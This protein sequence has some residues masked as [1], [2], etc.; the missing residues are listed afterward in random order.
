MATEV[1]AQAT[2][3]PF[4]QNGIG[5]IIPAGSIANF[6]MG[7]VGISNG[8]IRYVNVSNP[9]LLTY[10]SV[11]TFSAGIV[12]GNVKLSNGSAVERFGSANL[13]QINMSF[14]VIAGKWTSALVLRPYSY[15]HYKYSNTVQVNGTT[16]DDIQKVEG[17]GGF[18]QLMW[19]NGVKITKGLSLGGHASYIFGSI[20]KEY[21]NQL[22]DTVVVTAY[23]PTRT[24]SDAVADFIYGLGASYSYN[25]R[26]KVKL[27]F[28]LTY[29]FQSNVKTKKFDS[30]ERQ[31]SAGTSSSVFIL[32]DDAKGMTKLPSSLGLGI[33]V[34]NSLKWSAGVDIKMQDWSQFRNFEGSNEGLDKAFSVALGGEITPDAG[35]INNFLKR[36][37]YRLGLSYEDTPYSENGNS[38]QDFGINFGFSLPVTT[39]S[40]LDMGFKYG[41]RGNV[42]KVGLKEDYFRFQLGIT[43]NDRFW[44]IKRKFD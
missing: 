43:F 19:S 26:E 35:D 33:S 32:F 13:S 3:S 42:A 37:T 4:T 7:G 17:S 40:S 44:F 15:V 12:G 5:D 38:V 18:N 20:E 22:D 6:G 29:D 21:S 30:F 34:V 24:E 28:G 10:N 31:N 25:L 1:C 36:V 2:S 16:T 41:S 8:D 23:V 27:N 14:P 11:Y 39:I 9:A